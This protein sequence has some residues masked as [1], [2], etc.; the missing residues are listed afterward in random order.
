ML[1]HIHTHTLHGTAAVWRGIVLKDNTIP[2][3]IPLISYSSVVTLHITL[4]YEPT[5]Q[6]HWKAFIYKDT[7]HPWRERK[8]RE[9]RH[10][11]RDVDGWWQREESERNS[12]VRGEDSLGLSVNNRM[13]ATYSSSIFHSEHTAT[14]QWPWSERGTRAVARGTAS[15]S[16]K[17]NSSTASATAPYPIDS[18]T[19]SLTRSSLP[20]GQRCCHKADFSK[21]PN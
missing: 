14:A 5:R 17:S 9:G 6:Q 15:L 4:S 12:Q 11:E 2:W 19:G 16:L 7:G 10:F 3:F 13:P 18:L 21:C 1:M 20:I 8:S